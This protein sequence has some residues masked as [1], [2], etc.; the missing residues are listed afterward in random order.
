VCPPNPNAYRE[1]E[2]F[3]ERI[4]EDGEFVHENPASVAQ[5]GSA[6]VSH[7]CI[8]LNRDDAAWFFQTFG[9]GDVVEV[10]HSGGPVLPI[11]DTFGDWE[12]PWATWQA[13][14]ALHR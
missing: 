4:S 14:S 5:Q 11:T 10:V 12:V 1:N 13:G 6:N 2:S 9:L 8:N 3:A 7:G